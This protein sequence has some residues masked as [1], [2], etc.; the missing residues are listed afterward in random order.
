MKAIFNKGKLCSNNFSLNFKMSKLGLE[1]LYSFGIFTFA[2]KM[3]GTVTKNKK[4]SAGRRL[5]P[6]KY[7]EAEVYS[8]DIL[9]KQR[10]LKW[11]PGENVHYGRDHTLHAS[12]EGKMVLTYDPYI[13]YKSVRAHVI[14]QEIPNRI[15]KPPMPFL[16]HPELY[17]ELAKNNI[18]TQPLKTSFCIESSK[19]KKQFIKK[20][21][22]LNSSNEYSTQIKNIVE[23]TL[24]E[25]YSTNENGRNNIDTINKAIVFQNFQK[26][27]SNLISKS[28]YENKEVD[29]LT[30]TLES[31]SDQ[32]NNNKETLSK[33]NKLA[34]ELLNAS[35]LYKNNLIQKFLFDKDSDKKTMDNYPDYESKLK[36]IST[37]K[38]KSLVNFVNNH[39][40]TL[41]LSKLLLKSQL[42]LL[43]K[44]KII[45]ENLS[46]AIKS[47]EKLQQFSDN[48][49]NVENNM[50]T[51]Y[52]IIRYGGNFF[53]LG[54]LK[55]V[56]FHE[57][58]NL[59][60]FQKKLSKIVIV[61]NRLK[62]VK[63][64][65]IKAIAKKY[66]SV[67]E[68]KK[69]IKAKRKGIKIIKSVNQIKDRNIANRAK[70]IE[71]EDKVKRLAIERN[72][73]TKDLSTLVT[74]RKVKE[75]HI[76]LNELVKKSEKRNSTSKNVNF[77]DH[78]KIT[79]SE[80]EKLNIQNQQA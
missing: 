44:C 66:F 76:L 33:N 26:Y 58:S 16:Y 1:N 6:R 55:E 25:K 79:D 9:V 57:L 77:K 18:N 39:K 74:K 27:T 51:T 75:A 13:N 54:E 61:K 23:N 37:N 38:L 71:L 68:A 59:S 36:L 11:K 12:K 17:P 62:L 40:T 48:I 4:D 72:L 24:V 50:S 52:F 70:T 15:V 73:F 22:S 56:I 21:E 69:T 43:K 67:K 60:T 49:K 30:N 53:N 64:N 29:K 19:T 14:E 78:K 41:S 80:K 34:Y 31:S 45:S 10:G 65:N 28:L 3:R 42:L 35:L 7:G 20:L 5:G 63:L 2:T 32:S 46:S 8:N 47:E